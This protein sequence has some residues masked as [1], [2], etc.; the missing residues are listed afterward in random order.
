L[1]LGTIALARFR[2][3]SP[4]ALHQA[5]ELQQWSGGLV[6][7]DAASHPRLPPSDLPP[8]PRPSGLWL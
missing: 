7:P 6:A 2:C 8:R 5:A 4:P 1:D 3:V